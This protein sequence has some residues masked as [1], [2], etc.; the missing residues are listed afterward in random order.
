MKQ[1]YALKKEMT[2]KGKKEYKKMEELK[3]R[4]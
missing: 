2:R 3:R 4:T 1:I